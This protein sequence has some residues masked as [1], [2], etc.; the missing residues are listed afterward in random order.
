[1]KEYSHSSREGLSPRTPEQNEVRAKIEHQIETISPEEYDKFA[2]ERRRDEFAIACKDL[3]AQELDPSKLYE[4]LEVGAGT[5]IS[6]N[7]L[8]ELSN[9]MVTALEKR[10]D[11]LDYGIKHG[12]IT[13]EQATIGDFNH[14]SFNDNSF[15]L[16]TGIAI[17]NQ[18]N[19]VNKFYEEVVRVLRKDGLLFIPWTKTRATS[20]ERE[21]AFFQQFSITVV[22]EGDWFL[23]GKK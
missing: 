20:I 6:T 5:G 8:N 23:L 18:R 2:L 16:Y 22:K 21:K 1:M 3:L 15:D 4:T 7:R 13:K 10:K 14:L 17:L 19:D 9:L 12:K 11:F